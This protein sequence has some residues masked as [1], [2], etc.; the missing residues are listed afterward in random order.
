MKFKIIHIIAAVSV[1]TS[2]NGQAYVC[3]DADGKKTYQNWP[4]NELPPSP[5]REAKK[6]AEKEKEFVACAFSESLKGVA[7]MTREKCK[8]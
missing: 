5:G 1:S 8:R 2:V 4:C 7:G 6:K 3:K